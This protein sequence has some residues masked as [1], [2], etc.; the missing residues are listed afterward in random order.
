MVAA[1][2]PVSDGWSTALWLRTGNESLEGRE[3]AELLGTSQFTEVVAAAVRQRRVWSG[4]R[5]ELAH[6]VQ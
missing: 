4:E 1:L 2:E 5:V 6:G 3:P